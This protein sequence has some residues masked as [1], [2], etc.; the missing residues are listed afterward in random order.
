MDFESHIQGAK[1]VLV[2]YYAGWSEPCKLLIPVLQ[3]VKEQAGDRATVLQI[4]I[5]QDKPYADDY[6]VYAVPTLILFKQGHVLWRKTG[7][8]SAHEILEHLN[9]LME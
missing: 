7:L 6:Q 8:A 4:D 5:E 2:E 9:L 3:E 1:P